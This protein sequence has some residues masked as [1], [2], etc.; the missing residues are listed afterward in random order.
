MLRKSYMTRNMDMTS[1]EI[2]APIAFVIIR[3]TK[4]DTME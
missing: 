3:K 1:D 2:E 4:K